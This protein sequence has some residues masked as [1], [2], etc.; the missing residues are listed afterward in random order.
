VHHDIAR[1][2]HPGIEPRDDVAKKLTAGALEEGHLFDEGGGDR[3]HSKQI[4]V[5]LARPLGGHLGDHMD[6]G[7]H[8]EL[9]QAVGDEGP[10]VFGTGRTVGLQDDVGV[11]H[12][13]PPG[14]P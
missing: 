10:Q 8:H 4:A 2:E 13:A 7:R 1:R 14:A 9:R 6:V 5:D 3:P 12:L 11:R